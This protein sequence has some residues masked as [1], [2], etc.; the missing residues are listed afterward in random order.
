MSEHQPVLLHEAISYLDIK[1]EGVYVDLT[2]G[3]GGHSK[4]ILRHLSP[5][6]K[7]IAFDVD[8]EAIKAGET[9][10]KDSRF[11]LIRENFANFLSSLNEIGVKSVNGILADLGVSSPQ[12][13]EASRGFSYRMDAPL[14][15]R[16]DKR[17][18]LTAEII[19]NEYKESA[20]AK[21]L[22]EYGEEKDAR[23]IASLIVKEREETPIRTTTQ[24]AELVKKAKGPKCR[25]QKGHPAKQTFQALRMETNAE[26]SSLEKMLHD[27]PEALAIKG[28]G[29]VI[30]FHSLEDRMVKQH[31]RLLTRVE[32]SRYYP[33][34]EER[35]FIDLTKKPI[36]ASEEEIEH[37]HRAH[38]AKLR[39][40][41]RSRL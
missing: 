22:W 23:K 13:D 31:F 7:L 27:L 34:N 41:E 10:S 8:D 11:L 36:V 19:V 21:I 1:P 25:H 18:S 6:G 15:M 37:N 5:K 17:N 33:V 4:E 39:A 38:S 30:T 20:L 24:L 3:R 26:L 16:M 9:L 14:D 28:R 2:F 12:F 40:I 35:K 29:V 32:G